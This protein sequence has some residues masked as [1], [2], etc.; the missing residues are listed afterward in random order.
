ML[1][2]IKRIIISLVVMI[3]VFFIGFAVYTD[4]Y[5]PKFKDYYGLGSYE[6]YKDGETHLPYVYKEFPKSDDYDTRKLG[7]YV[8]MNK[9][10]EVK[11]GVSNGVVYADYTVPMFTVKKVNGELQETMQDL[12]IKVIYKDLVD[13]QY[14][15]FAPKLNTYLLYTKDLKDT[16]VGKIV[17][18]VGNWISTKYLTDMISYAKSQGI[19]IK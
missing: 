15:Y 18:R 7:V 11:K 13:I 14:A 9:L 19:E 2:K 16:N 4:W 10:Q 1:N 8:D 17:P 5:F 6:M 3:V 12:R